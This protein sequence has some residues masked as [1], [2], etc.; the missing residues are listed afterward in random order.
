MMNGKLFKN[1]YRS[2]SLRLKSWDYSRNGGY[3]VTICIQGKKFRLCEIKNGP[4]V[5]NDGGKI[6]NKIW[7]EIPKHFA[8]IVLDEFV[9]MPDHVHGII[10]VDND[11]VDVAYMQ[12]VRKNVDPIQYRVMRSK[13][14]LS[15]VIQQFK[16]AVT[17]EINRKCKIDFRWQ[18]N[19][20]E[21]IIRNENELQRIRK[22]IRENPVKWWLNNHG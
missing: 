18:R 20:Y 6:V 3:F 1:K 8:N 10:I 19:Y 22:Y 11:T 7:H 21:R 12:H 15:R 16:S 5:L 17:R 9:V 4:V 14:L 13:M 2:N